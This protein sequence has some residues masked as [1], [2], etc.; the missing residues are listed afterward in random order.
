MLIDREVFVTEIA[1][2]ADR[3]GRELKAPTIAALY[4]ILG[5]E[6]TTEEFVIG[7]RRVMRRETF[8]PSPQ[9]IIDAARVPEQ[10]VEQTA[11]EVFDGIRDYR[12]AWGKDPRAVI[13]MKRAGGEVLVRS[14][15]PRV[16]AFAR[17]DFIAAYVEQA[18][19]SATETEIAVLAAT[20]APRIRQQTGTRQIGGDVQRVIA[21]IAAPE[22][23]R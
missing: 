13:A 21:K 15:D 10:P 7:C 3:Y 9:Q 5:A 8:F 18:K 23:A 19:R 22:V 1:V 6:L 11:A 20:T 4:E 16:M 12:L 14:D 17:R 2:L